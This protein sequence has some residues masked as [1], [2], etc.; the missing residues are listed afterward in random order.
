LQNVSQIEVKNVPNV[1]KTIEELAAEELIAEM[2]GTKEHSV[3]NILCIP[4]SGGNDL[5]NVPGN[6]PK[7]AAPLL[8]G[9]DYLRL[10][11]VYV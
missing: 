2:T 8:A 4:L 1:P 7:K 3:E 9:E 5:Q 6:V 11:S 10:L